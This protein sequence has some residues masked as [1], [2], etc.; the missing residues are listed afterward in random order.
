[1]I[2]IINGL[3]PKV[4][5]F[6]ATGTV[7]EDD[8]IKIVN[9][10]CDK[11]YKEYNRIN[12]LLV[13]ATPLKKFTAGAWIKDALLGFIYFTDWKR[14]AIVSEQKGIKDF[15]NFFGKLI[16]GKTKGFMMQDLEDAKRWVSEQSY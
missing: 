2:E 7:T 6:K 4:A 1:M 15:T 14:I 5:A 10:L 13:I 9:P 11:V 16:P 8:Y 3:S 12:Y